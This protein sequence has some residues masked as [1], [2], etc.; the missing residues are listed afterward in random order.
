MFFSEVLCV[1]LSHKA[2]KLRSIL[3]ANKAICELYKVRYMDKNVLSAT[4]L[5]LETRKEYLW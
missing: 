4:P 3:I 2:E 1:M 5:M